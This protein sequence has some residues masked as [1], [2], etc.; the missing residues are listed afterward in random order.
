MM[1]TVRPCLSPMEA[2]LGLLY[3]KL[4]PKLSVGHVKMLLDHHRH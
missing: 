4:D 1:R 2:M 3:K